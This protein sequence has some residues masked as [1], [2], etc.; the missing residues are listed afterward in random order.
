MAKHKARFWEHPA[1]YETW[2]VYWAREAFYD[3]ILAN[4]IKLAQALR[5]RGRAGSRIRSWSDAIKPT[6]W[7]RIPIIRGGK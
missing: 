3:A 7:V 2:S 4:D 5:V 6:V 1:A